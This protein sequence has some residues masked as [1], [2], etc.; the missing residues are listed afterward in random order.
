MAP[1]PQEDFYDG[2]HVTNGVGTLTG[3]EIV[4][5]GMS[6]IFPKSKNV[7]E[8]MDNL[9]NQ[10]DMVSPAFQNVKH[11][12]A[13]KY[14]GKIDGKD[15]FDAQFFRVTYNQA[16]TLD[17]AT[18][19]SMEQAYGA[20]FDAGENPL[21]YKG[22]KIGV[23]AGNGF[24]DASSITSM[25]QQLSDNNFAI[26]GCSSCMIANRVSFFLDAKAPSVFMTC[27]CATGMRCL[28]SAH[29]DIKTGVCEAA[30][31]AACQI[32][33]HHIL[34]INLRKAGL[35][36]LDGKT[37]CFDKDADGY[38]RSESIS[39][40]FL[41]K[42]KTAKRIYAEVCAV[43]TRYAL[44]GD[45]Q[46]LPIREK[47]NIKAFLE[48]F[49]SEAGV[50]PKDVEYVEANGAAL[51][52]GDINELQAISDVFASERS[53]K[54]GC[55]KSNMGSSE[56]A[57]GLCGITK[58]CLAYHKGE[59]PGNLHYNKPLDISP[60][61][62]GKVKILSENTPFERG[63]TAINTFTY[64]GLNCHALL[65]GHFIPKNLNRYDCKIPRLVCISGRQD[66]GVERLFDILKSQPIDAEQVGL[67]HNIYQMDIPGHTCRGY[68]ILDTDDNKKTVSLSQSVEL[69]QGARRPLW[70]VFSGMGSQ[71]AGMGTEL[72]RIPI[73][74]AAI[75]KCDKVLKPKGLDI[76]RIITEPDAK[77]VDDILNCYV[78][79]AAIQIGLT[80]IL[81]AIGLVP[82]GYIGHSVGEMG[83]AYFDGGF[84]AEEFIL[85]AYSRGLVSVETKFIEGSMAAIGLGYKDVLPILPPTI[86]IACR[87]SFESC[88]ISGP[89]DCVNKFVKDL[90]NKG[91][92]AKQ[93]PT[94][95]IA[96]HS[97]YV[98]DGG[99]RFLKLLKQ[100]MGEP[101]PR[102]DK[103]ICSSL[104]PEKWN[105]PIAKQ[106]SPEY[107]EN[108]L[109]SPVYFED[110][111]MLIP[112][113]A[114]VVEVAPHGL[115]QAIIKRSHPDCSHIPLTKKG[116][117]D[118]VRF[119]LES[120]G[121][122]YL[123][124]YNPKIHELYPKIEY[125]VSTETPMLSHFI[126]WYHQEEWPTTR[127]NDGRYIQVAKRT[128][129]MFI[130]DDDYKFISGH[131]INGD[132]LFPEAGVLFLIWE[133]FAMY[134]GVHYENLPVSFRD[135]HFYGDINISIDLKKVMKLDILITKGQQYFEITRDGN[136]V[137]SGFIEELENCDPIKIDKYDSRYCNEGIKLD[138]EDI[139]NIFRAKGYDYNN[140][141]ESM[142]TSST[143]WDNA[144][145]KWNGNWITFLD[146]LIQLNILARNHN[147][148]SAVKLIKYLNIKVDDHVCKKNVHDVSVQYDGVNATTRC[149]GV[150][151]RHVVLNDM[152]AKTEDPDVLQTFSFVPH[153]AFS[154]V[155]LEEA[156]Q[157]NLQLVADN[158][159][160][161][162]VN[163]MTVGEL[164]S[165]E[166]IVKSIA[167]YIPDVI[168]K[169][170]TNR[171][172]EIQSFSKMNLIVV[173]NLFSDLEYQTI[174][175]HIKNNTFVLTFENDFGCDT[176]SNHAF[177]V[178][179]TMEVERQKII[180]LRKT[181]TEDNDTCFVPVT[182]D[183]KYL[184][185]SR[186]HC[187]LQVM[188]KVILV[189]EKES[190]NGVYGLV[191]KLKKDY[192][193]RIGVIIIEDD[194]APS[195]D[196]EDD[197]YKEQLQKNLVFN[198]IKQGQWG[199]YYYL[200]SHN[201]TL[202][203]A[204]NFNLV[205]SV[206]GDLEGMK[207]VAS[208]SE[209]KAKNIVKVCFAGPSLRDTQKAAGLVEPQ[210]QG[211]GMDFS[212][213]DSKG[214]RV[215]GLVKCGAL[216]STVEAD[217]DLLWPVPE[218]WTLEEA[219]TVPLP[220]IQ[221]L[222]CLTIKGQLLPRHSVFVTG[223]AGALGQAV[224]SL[225]LGLGC[226]VY[227]SVGEVNKKRFLL[228]LFPQ[229]QDENIGYSYDGS[230][231]NT[232]FYSKKNRCDF[233]INC[234]TGP[235]R[236]FAMNGVGPFGIFFDVNAYNLLQS[237]DFGMYYLD[238]E[239][240]Y[241]V[242]NLSAI[243]DSE[244]EKKALQKSLSEGIATGM[245]KPLSHVTYSTE[246]VSR[247]FRFLTTRKHR[248]RVLIDI[249][250]HTDKLD[251]VPRMKIS[252]T[253]TYIVVCDDTQLGIELAN[254]LVKHGA[255]QI[256]LH[257]KQK[258]SK[259]YLDMMLAHWKKLN[260]SVHI[261]TGKLDC[262]MSCVKFLIDE[263][264]TAQ[265][266]GIFIIQG[267]SKT[268]T[269]EQE[270]FVNKSNDLISIATNLSLVS[271]NNCPE[272]R[273]F[274]IVARSSQNPIDEY[275]TSV[276][277]K[278]CKE[279]AEMNLPSLV[280]RVITAD[281]NQQSTSNTN[282]KP[283]TIAVA[284]NALETSLSHNHNNALAYNVNESV[285]EEDDIMAK[286]LRI[287]G[288][289]DYEKIDEDMALDSLLT[290]EVVI[291]ELKR[292]I[293][294]YSGIEFTAEELK[295]TSLRR[296]RNLETVHT[297][298]NT[299]FESG[300]SAF[301]NYVDEDEI[302]AT[303]VLIPMPTASEFTD[304][305]IFLET[306][307][308]Y[309][310]LLPGF[311][312]HHHIFKSICERLKIG[313]VALQLRPNVNDNSIHETA[314]DIKHHIMK[315]FSMKSK[316]YLLGYSYGVNVALEVAA[317]FEKEGKTGVVYCLDSSPDALR[318]QLDAYLGNLTE[319]QLQNAIITHLFKT[320]TG[321][322]NEQ[323]AKDL[324][325]TNEWS[326]KIDLCLQ[327]LYNRV[328]YTFEYCKDLIE[329]AYKKMK[330][331]ISYKPDFKL[332][333]EIVLLKGIPHPKADSLPFDYNLSK[334]STKPVKVY[335]INSDV[336]SA[337]ED[338][339]VSNIV[340]RLL[341]PS[342]LDEFKKRN[343][344]ETYIVD[345]YKLSSTTM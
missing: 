28:E 98:K 37:R 43:K 97:R 106:S 182:Q 246:E 210:M 71:W 108:N 175:N 298:C 116:H 295:K 247:A 245:V 99:P 33:I 110:A 166:K 185:V 274:A 227:T 275:T 324:E 73:F 51:P 242:V 142:K 60:V 80:D 198:V 112:R 262:E 191:K 254:R 320:M 85:A 10:V 321:E 21:K 220:Y 39:Y 313:A 314:V 290:T 203:K 319:N 179:S 188:R 154:Q 197:I 209:S 75:A 234:M 103:W 334:Y 269:C 160:D 162:I 218:H 4:I 168:L 105:E 163:I 311:E 329:A 202:S 26:S 11:S 170:H 25:Y 137:A 194:E 58:I 222:Y 345:E 82:D 308:T 90:K 325:E 94:G 16:L 332:E 177:N 299:K 121:K 201:S 229:L 29:N 100:F 63:L 81:K 252:S 216:S 286:I 145:V 70:L 146:S 62:E 125:P 157:I 288:V 165:L 172:K 276:L 200:P 305:E 76:Y 317:L 135:V 340:N 6:G 117:S 14:M 297:Y 190:L 139:Y 208:N 251:V 156:L 159:R 330:L 95:N 235:D 244:D 128:F 326:K 206:A 88:T 52:E 187:E 171:G 148:V 34:P 282:L 255:K 64:T 310:M 199:S 342:L 328:S 24:S 78:G 261:S 249:G 93:V 294:E 19:K 169:F 186:M 61:Q 47:E 228:K 120:L 181:S 40:L 219:A 221:A 23:Y 92:F 336:S 131:V 253:G 259:G 243:F 331:A 126:D 65:K 205:N 20:I 250:N 91:I 239:R 180:L 83:C 309:L 56:S 127:F 257:M 68:T 167:E 344:C 164:H 153:C 104:P 45:E 32:C 123:E 214:N 256:T 271:K 258:K 74:A 136:V 161:N 327:Y 48:K 337:T 307:S 13:P 302:T 322:S 226:T 217:L 8:F 35:V 277:E 315:R 189:T 341:D 204:T 151:M 312:G 333:S 3:E 149:D 12:E 119:L 240:S 284:L 59:M 30:L 155:K 66:T 285:P 303:Q 84:T 237:N 178:I 300:M 293:K 152:P 224:I 287:I 9:Y 338:L 79:I 158:L 46:F 2:V 192:H 86:D 143:A 268:E 55:V 49:Y 266:Q 31:V 133:T 114:V 1:S 270:D 195:W 279:R 129:S 118:P 50:S 184:W 241:S 44:R 38:V 339:K 107:H 134:K 57:S 5:S 176:E 211:F 343:L 124:G 89:A 122:L 238:E 27:S 225:C 264:V 281:K 231:I 140:E 15:K 260:I 87:N 69:Y 174:Y 7:L 150:E 267:C 138:S 41:Q 42:A 306:D 323:L 207:W 72:M 141:F 273:Y 230:F 236:E 335:E 292:V 233:V 18:R 144:E 17:P 272:L 36:S 109:L 291:E 22:K 96:Y 265:V 318:I 301:Y 115:L 113:D 196:P 289:G 278:I 54:V 101:A 111:A 130:E 316:F 67:L 263:Q 296:L 213:I 102:S 77:I 193:D 53:V 232:L 212:G 283:L 215:M 173:E 147:G 183:N 280:L 248:G 304:N 223:G 132:V